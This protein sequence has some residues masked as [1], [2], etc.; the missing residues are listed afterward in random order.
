MSHARRVVRV[1]IGQKPG[2]VRG[3]GSSNPNPASAKNVGKQPFSDMPETAIVYQSVGRLCIRGGDTGGAGSA[4]A[5]E[6][7]IL[8]SFHWHE[9]RYKVGVDF[10]CEDVQRFL[11]AGAAQPLKKA[12]GGD[13][14]IAIPYRGYEPTAIR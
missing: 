13:T 8:V 7:I 2:V 9:W 12:F 6:P 4:S 14:R 1:E 11:V 5:I 10:V 3:T